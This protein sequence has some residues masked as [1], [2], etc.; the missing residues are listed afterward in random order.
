M[1]QTDRAYAESLRD[2]GV[3]EGDISLNL[4]ERMY[5]RW[6]EEQLEDQLEGRQPW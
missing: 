1:Y 6:C 5:E 2:E 4:E 3:P